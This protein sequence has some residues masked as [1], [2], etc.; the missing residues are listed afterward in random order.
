MGTAKRQRQKEGRQARLEAREAADRRERIRRR[1][2]SGVVVFVVV[3]VALVVVAQ[4][5]GDDGDATSTPTS[6]STSASTST[7]TESGAAGAGPAAFTY[8]TGPCPPAEKPARPVRSFDA[9][10][11]R[12]IEE[13]VDYGAV[14]RTSEG[15]FTV[16]LLE[17]AA[18]GTVNNFVALARYGYF[19]GDDFH[20][21][22][23]DF[24]VQAGDPVG[25][26]PGTGGPG[27]TIPDELPAGADAY[28]E[29]S[30]AMANSGPDTAGSQWFVYV[31]PNPLPGPDFP[32]FGQVTEGLDVVRAILALATAG[33]APS[34]PVEITSVEITQS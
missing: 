33:P 25:D 11:R 9:A 22:V 28:V 1:L 15:D 32:L 14:V 2:V 12:C 26:P 10:P 8:G 13:S 34:R 6:A 17:D 18:P 30:V 19:D 27:Y 5:G 31:G 24:V 4:T 16:N 7:S 23:A 20:R 3:A 21:V 29:G